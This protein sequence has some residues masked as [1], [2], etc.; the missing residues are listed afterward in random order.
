MRVR[1]VE[2]PPYGAKRP[3]GATGLLRRWPARVVLSLRLTASAGASPLSAYAGEC[4]VCA[5]APA[6]PKV[7]APPRS[8]SSLYPRA[9][10]PRSSGREPPRKKRHRGRARE[11]RK[12]RERNNLFKIY[13]EEKRERFFFKKTKRYKELRGKK[14]R[15]RG[16]LVFTRLDVVDTVMLRARAKRA[17]SE[18]GSK[19]IVRPASSAPIL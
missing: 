16:G 10:R 11:P 5:S 15:C 2:A 14:E 1:T 18:K 12:G 7:R 9:D 3:R 8:P 19:K 13:L 4:A 17:C 6:S